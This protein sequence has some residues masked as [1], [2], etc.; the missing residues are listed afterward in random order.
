MKN[1]RDIIL[2]LFS[3]VA[4]VKKS[5]NDN[6]YIELIISNDKVNKEYKLSPWSVSPKTINQIGKGWTLT[7]NHSILVMV[8]SKNEILVKLF[9]ENRFKKLNK[10]VIRQNSGISRIY[11]LL[12]KLYYLGKKAEWVS[13]PKYNM[14]FSFKLAESFKSFKE[15]KNYLG[16]DFIS[17]DA[18]LKLFT[19]ISFNPYTNGQFICDIILHDLDR[20]VLANTTTKWTYLADMINMFKQ[21]NLPIEIYESDSRNKEV[22]NHLVKLINQ[23]S[24]DVLSDEDVR[25]YTGDFVEELN[26]LYEVEWLTSPRKL[27]IAG[28]RNKH[29]IGTYA[30]SLRDCLF[31]SILHENEY[32]EF[33]VRLSDTKIIQVHGYKNSTAPNS[34]ISDVDLLIQ[35]YGIESKP[36]D[37]VETIMSSNIRVVNQEPVW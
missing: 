31:F 18:M 19:K 3:S 7:T 20:V 12:I 36:V 13:D 5:K 35:T 9:N 10:N 6:Y 2:K 17:E 11:S 34:I 8:N 16:F 28:L 26:K 32:Y 1:K 14:F 25:T 30:H 29:C 33:Q 4:E 22:H 21:M 24:L 37:I 23:K 15:F 27:A